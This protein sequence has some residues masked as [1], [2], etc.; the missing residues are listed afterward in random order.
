MD[1]KAGEARREDV[2]RVRSSV[3]SYIPGETLNIPKS[4][5]GWNNKVTARLLC[6]QTRLAEF[7]EDWER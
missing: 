6:P 5:R 3:M 7:D 2:N 1:H 4:D